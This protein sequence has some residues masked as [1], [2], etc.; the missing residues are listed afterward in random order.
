ML[1]F[2]SFQN[3]VRAKLF[4]KLIQDTFNNGSFFSTIP[5]NQSIWN[6]IIKNLKSEKKLLNELEIVLHSKNQYSSDGS[7][8]TNDENPLDTKYH[9]HADIENAVNKQINAEFTAAYAYL[10]LACYFGRSNV[11]LLGTQK[12]FMD[13]YNEEV[14]HGMTL[15][16]FQ[17][18]RGGNVKIGTLKP[19]TCEGCSILSSLRISLCME[20][21]ITEQ[22]LKVIES[23]KKMDDIRTVDF[24]TNEFIK[25]QMESI[26]QLGILISM[27]EMIGDSG[28]SQY[29]MDLKLKSSGGHSK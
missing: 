6:N 18:M 9:Y 21:E 25:E 28:L 14:D 1:L 19:S 26:R 27:A 2:K 29:F 23:A 20:K 10:G 24:L 16:K 15:I 4:Q 11:G 5:S 22:L 12:F 17:E 8:C 13:M 7:D 3:Y